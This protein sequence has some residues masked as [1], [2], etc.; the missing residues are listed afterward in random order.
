[1]ARYRLRFKRSVA[2][3]LRKIPNADVVRI[4]T[5]IDSLSENPRGPGVKKL[6]AR[7]VYRMRQG[8]YRIIYE[9]Q[10]D[11]LVVHVIRVAHRSEAYES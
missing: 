8:A 10:D 9:I 1:M 2:K 7:E 4:L 11:L 6:A 3:D 5:R